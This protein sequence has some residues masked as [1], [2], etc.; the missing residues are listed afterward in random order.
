MSCAILCWFP[1]HCAFRI[2]WILLNTLLRGY[3]NNSLF[4]TSLP[5]PSLRSLQQDL[6]CRAPR[7]RP[8]RHPELWTRQG[9]GLGL[10]LAKSGQKFID[11][12]KTRSLYDIESEYSPG[13]H[14]TY[15]NILDPSQVL[16]NSESGCSLS[17]TNL[18]IARIHESR[19]I[20]GQGGLDLGRLRLPRANQ[21][22]GNRR[23][24]VDRHQHWR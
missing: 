10:A 18:K 16:G 9:M 4:P 2:A 13:S 21:A 15:R 7:T 12:R 23:R 20:S 17:D 6:H 11:P 1:F 22:R 5:V 24:K 8:R 19:F 3:P 14:S